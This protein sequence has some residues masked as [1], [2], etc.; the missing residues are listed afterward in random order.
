M[1]P[2]IRVHIILPA[3]LLAEVDRVAGK[4]KRSHFVESAIR[5]KLSRESL[6][7]ALRESA[8]AIGLESYPQWKTPEK[9]SAWVRSMRRR[10]D[11]RPT[12]KIRR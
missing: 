5:E 7:A 10:D 4:R 6:S 2:P 9:V 3:D 8:G 1:T 12:R 11:V